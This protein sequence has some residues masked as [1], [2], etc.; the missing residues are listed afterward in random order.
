ML[1]LFV[2]ICGVFQPFA[3]TIKTNGTSYIFYLFTM[4]AF[5]QKGIIRETLASQSGFVQCEKAC[6]LIYIGEGIVSKSP[7][8]SQ[9]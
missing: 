8:S 5:P 3:I 4:F 6:N 1:G 9:T 7:E 2:C